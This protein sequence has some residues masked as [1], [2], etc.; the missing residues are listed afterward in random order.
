LLS[1][2]LARQFETISKLVSQVPEGTTLRAS[3]DSALE[4]AS[5]AVGELKSLADA[6][7]YISTLLSIEGHVDMFSMVLSSW[8]VEGCDSGSA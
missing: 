6:D 4:Q 5:F 3:L 7:D 1:A 8:G 2:D